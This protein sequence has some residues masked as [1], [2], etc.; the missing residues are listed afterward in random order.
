[1]V[2][3]DFEIECSHERKNKCGGLSLASLKISQSPQ[4]VSQPL[5]GPVLQT[6]WSVCQPVACSAKT[7]QRGRTSDTCPTDMEFPFSQESYN[8]ASLTSPLPTAPAHAC[9]PSFGL[10]LKAGWLCWC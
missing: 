6:N 1:M 7:G 8:K 2:A 4:I 3:K 9:V 10:V 5:G